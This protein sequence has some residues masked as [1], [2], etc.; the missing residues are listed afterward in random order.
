[1]TNPRD[2]RAIRRQREG[3]RLDAPQPAARLR[4]GHPDPCHLGIGEGDRRD[5]AL[6][7]SSA[8][9]GGVQPGDPA[10]VRG[11]VRELEPAGDVAGGEHVAGARPAAA[12]DPHIAA[13]QLDADRGETETVERRATPGGDEQRITCEL[14]TVEREHELVAAPTCRGDR[15]TQPQLD[16]LRGERFRHQLAGLGLLARQQPLELLDHRDLAAEAAERLRQLEADGA[17]AEDK[18]P[19]WQPLEPEHR[20]VGQVGEVDQAR[21][22][23]QRRLAARRDHEALADERPLAELQLLRRREAGGAVQ[24]VD[25]LVEE[26]FVALVARDLLDDSRPPL[27]D[28]HE[29]EWRQLTDDSLRAQPAQVVH[30]LGDLDQCLRGDAAGEGAVAA[31]PWPPLDQRHPGSLVSRRQRRGHP[32]RAAANDDHIE[33]S[34]P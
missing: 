10:L 3:D 5:D 17:A 21:D 1:L 33:P 26:A 30:E 2:R 28:P 24:D 23:G 8:L 20:L 22:G 11:D 4:L 19:P 6:I 16:A 34:R 18:Q 7:R 27:R 12:V 29:G 31:E 25:P 32:G 13:V 9:A 15:R 14:L